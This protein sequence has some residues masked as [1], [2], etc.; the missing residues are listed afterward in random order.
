[1]SRRDPL[2]LVL[3]SP[4]AFFAWHDAATDAISNPA[5]VMGVTGRWP[6]SARTAEHALVAGGAR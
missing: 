5:G 6:R 2:P 1:M 4:L 3:V